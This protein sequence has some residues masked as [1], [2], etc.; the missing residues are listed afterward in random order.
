[1]NDA[2]CPPGQIC[3]N[4]FCQSGSGGEGCSISVKCKTGLLTV[5]CSGSDCK[6]R[7]CKDENGGADYSF[8]VAVICDGNITRCVNDSVCGSRGH[9][10]V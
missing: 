4:G 7:Y 2:D 6:T 5:S 3:V 1:M 8:V 10:D 9:V